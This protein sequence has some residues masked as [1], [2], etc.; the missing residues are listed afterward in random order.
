MNNPII[1]AFPLRGEWQSPNT[2][3]NKIPS[4][5]T[6]RFGTRYAYDFIQVD[7]T[8]RGW[9]AYRSS[10]PQY[11]IGGLPI[12]DYYCWGQKIYAPYDGI[13]VK[14]A[15][16]YEERQ[17]T[18]L[19]GDLKN[20]YQN[21]H[22]FDPVIDDPRTVA[23]NYIIIE[24][25]PTIYAALCHLQQDSV[26]VTEGQLIKKGDFLGRVGHSGN[27][28]APHLHFQLMNSSDITKAKGLPCAF[29]TYEVYRNGKWQTVD[30]GIPTSKD[31]IRFVEE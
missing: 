5:G 15:D 27:S 6:N 18:N 26:Q 29:E 21:A 25:S 12:S 4:H 28:F 17:Q 8:R 20:A 30:A 11:L 14:A 9:P 22:H 3:G 7:W 10:L 2:P 23:G 1:V 19:L 13:V 16:Q 31:R 24:H